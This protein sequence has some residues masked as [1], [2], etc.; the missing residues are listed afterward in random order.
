M[1]LAKILSGQIIGSL[2]PEAHRQRKV[3]ARCCRQ[4]SKIKRHFRLY[5]LRHTF[6]TRAAASGADL[7][8]LSV[9]LGHAS[10][11]MK[12]RYVHPAAE[13]KRKTIGKFEKFRTEGINCRCH[14]PAK[15]GGHYKSHYRGASELMRTIRKLLKRVAR[16]EGFEPP[17]L[18][19]EGRRSFQLS[20]GRVHCSDSKTFVPRADT[21]LDAL[22]FCAKGRRSFPTP[23]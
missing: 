1:S 15:S 7:P 10:I 22:T 11:Q 20:Y 9:L 14:C 19:L 13:Q 2:Q 23:P 3:G 21:V 16:P 8:I 12:M 18:C 6:A 17:T 5:D 4:A